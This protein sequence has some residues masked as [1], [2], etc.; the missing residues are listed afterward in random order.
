MCQLLPPH[1]AEAVQNRDDDRFVQP[2]SNQIERVIHDGAFAQGAA[3]VGLSQMPCGERPTSMVSKSPVSGCNTATF[4]AKRRVIHRLPSG[5]KSMSSGPPGT[6]KRFTILSVAASSAAV[7][8]LAR[9][10]TQRTF[11]SG[12]RNKL[13]APLPVTIRSTTSPV[14][15]SATAT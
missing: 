13:C 2:T 12:D 4:S 6:L 3:A 10:F 1:E 14:A 15:G 5:A 9:L 8:P 11:L 7:V